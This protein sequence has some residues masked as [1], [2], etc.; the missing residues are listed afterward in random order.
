[1]KHKIGIL[2]SGGLD[3]FLM[4]RFAKINYP[5]HEIVC[6]YYQHGAES[7]EK[8]LANLPEFVKVRKIDWLSESCKPVA[9]KDDPYAGAIYI[10]GRN[11][12]FATLIAS[13]ELV[14]EVWMGTVV[15]EDN[16]KATDKNEHFR[17][18][19][20]KLLTYVLSPFKEKVTVKFPF[21]EMAW[22][23]EHAVRWAL[24]NHACTKEELIET[25]SCW[26]WD[27][28]PCGK[29]KQCLKRALVFALNGFHEEYLSDP[30][31]NEF[32]QTLM[33]EYLDADPDTANADEINMKI[34]IENW[35]K[36][37]NER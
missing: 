28:K 26:H 4:H 11:L 12:V 32:G 16:F 14:D 15:D 17:H 24:Q 37:K 13:Q 25:V 23:K 27:G 9:K 2:Y 7:E 18:K 1:M 5:D 36:E 10:P 6:V 31:E 34:M 19:T 22:T 29:C 21:V 35:K 3:S 33:Q 30:L 8:E 20:S